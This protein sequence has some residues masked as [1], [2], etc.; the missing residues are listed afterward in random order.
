MSAV[1]G[2]SS[3]PPSW[4]D[5]DG[6]H[7]VV[8][9]EPAQQK[10]ERA[11]TAEVRAEVAAALARSARQRDSTAGGGQAGDRH[12]EVAALIGQAMERAAAAALRAG[13]PALDPAAE[14]R[15]SQA[16]T[17]SLLGLGG[18]QRL[19]DDPLVENIDV[20]GCDQVFV[21]YADGRMTRA[22]PAAA[23]DGELAELIR[24]IAA[25]AGNEERRFD[26]ASPSLTVQL[27][28]GSR[29]FAVM[30]VT[31]RPC[32]SVR[33]HRHIQVT[34]AGSSSSAPWTGRWRTSWPPRSAPARTS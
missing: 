14:E 17:D 12:G 22:A 16:V 30:S 9:G 27:P 4:L 13:R 28:D 7:A 25:R 19:L 20:N 1:N 33:R 32:V 18:L 3:L 5:G 11:V 6:Q 21:R 29:L 8:P 2:S 24:L 15:I 26:R 23:S 34:L 31:R 10:G